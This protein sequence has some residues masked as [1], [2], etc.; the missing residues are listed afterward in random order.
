[1]PILP[2]ISIVT[3]A[4][5]RKELLLKTLESVN[6]QSYPAKQHIIIDG[7]SN[8]GTK[9]LLLQWAD[10]LHYFVSEP[11]RNLYDAMNKGL[12]NAT[13]D[14]ILFLN[15]GDTLYSYETLSE[16]G[17]HLFDHKVGYFG[18]VE[19]TSKHRVWLVP[20]STHSKLE[21]SKFLPHHQSILYPRSFYGRERYNI[22]NRIHADIEFTKRAR[23]MVSLKQ[24]PVTVSK[25]TMGGLG[26][27][28]YRNWKRTK[29]LMLEIDSV[30]ARENGQVSLFRKFHTRLSLVSKYIICRLFGDDALHSYFYILAWLRFKLY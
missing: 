4:Y 27:E 24:V 8:D 12:D 19:I 6:S 1:V 30:Y 16:L 13:G 26:T 17:E 15:S 2:T 20:P 28:L 10:K 7:N 11:D 25:S 9:Q 3:V 21:A 22:S 5:N 14:F 18:R 23:N 29:E